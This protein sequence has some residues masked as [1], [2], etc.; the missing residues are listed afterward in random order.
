MLLRM[1]VAQ[2]IY[3]AVR[4]FVDTVSRPRKGMDVGATFNDNQ[5]LVRIYQEWQA[6]DREEM[7]DE[8]IRRWLY[9][10]R[11]TGGR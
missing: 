5:N 10:R 3:T 8:T 7:V 1:R 2:N 6:L 11:R 4:F 9:G